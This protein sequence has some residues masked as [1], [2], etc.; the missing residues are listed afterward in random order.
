MPKEPLFRKSS[1]TQNLITTKMPKNPNE[2]FNIVQRRAAHNSTPQRKTSSNASEDFDL[3]I[4]ELTNEQSVRQE[5]L[6]VLENEQDL[7][8]YDDYLKDLENEEYQ[9]KKPATSEANQDE[10]TILNGSLIDLNR[11]KL[12]TINESMTE[13]MQLNIKKLQL[14][15][16]EDSGLQQATGSNNSIHNETN[17]NAVTTNSVKTNNAKGKSMTRKPLPI[18][19]A[20][21]RT[22]NTPSNNNGNIRISNANNGTNSS[23]SINSNAGRTKN[24]P[25]HVPRANRSNNI[26]IRPYNNPSNNQHQTSKKPQPNTDS[27]R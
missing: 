11:S 20:N 24:L 22:K 9:V 21:S 19:Q 7:S 3:R 15:K 18:H 5:I 25:S 27:S 23:A 14:N 2:N 1:G 17:K 6:S 26:N 10:T 8:E 16:K 13:A 4:S 12:D